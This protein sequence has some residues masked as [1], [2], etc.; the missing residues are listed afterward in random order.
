MQ[1]V[2]SISRP[3]AAHALTMRS[4]KLTGW[5]HKAPYGAGCEVAVRTQSEGLDIGCV[6]PGSLCHTVPASGLPVPSGPRL[7]AQPK[8]TATLKVNQPDRLRCCLNVL[9]TQLGDSPMI[10]LE[11]DV[12]PVLPAVTQCALHASRHVL[13]SH[14]HRR[15][16]NSRQHDCR[17][18]QRDEHQTTHQGNMQT[19][20]HEINSDS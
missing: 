12:I 16:D 11:P 9:R 1:P 8:F 20:K 6:Q 2:I 15:L 17:C 4:M 19:I 10:D 18:G 14:L 13:V 7:P 3:T 5:L